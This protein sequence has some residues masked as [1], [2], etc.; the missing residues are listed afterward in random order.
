MEN[1]KVEEG[2]EREK[3]NRKSLHAVRKGQCGEDKG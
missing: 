1:R 2:G 3:L